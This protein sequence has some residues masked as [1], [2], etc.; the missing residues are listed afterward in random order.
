VLSRFA[1]AAAE[2]D[3]ALIVNPH[4]VEAVAEAIATALDMPLEER[5]ERHA[6]MF[7]HLATNDVD[8]WAELFLSALAESHQRP[9]FLS[10]R[11]QFSAS[12]IGLTG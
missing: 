4:E 12:R 2:L 10:G 1:G 5:K 8:R 3:G 11:E 6:R 9:G 7:A